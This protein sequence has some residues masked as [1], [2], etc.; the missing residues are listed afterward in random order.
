MVN[1]GSTTINSMAEHLEYLGYSIDHDDASGER[2]FLAVHPDRPKFVFR[3]F[4]GGVLFSLGFA[5]NKAKVEANMEGISHF[6]NQLNKNA[7]VM[8]CYTDEDSDIMVE[9]YFPDYYE[10]SGFGVFVD[11]WQRDVTEVFFDQGE[12]IENFFE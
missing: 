6:L 8:R 2:V 9:S 7:T 10:K 12:A 5:I 1:E 11:L 3:P 4:A